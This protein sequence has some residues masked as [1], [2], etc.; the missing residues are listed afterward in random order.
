MDKLILFI[1]IVCLSWPVNAQLK[2]PGLEAGLS[3]IVSEGRQAPFWL[4]SNRQGK[5]SPDRNMAALTLAAFALPDTGKVF[6]FH[7]GAEVYARQGHSGA[8]WLHQL[9]AGFT[10]RDLLE[11]RAGLWEE[12]IGSREPSLSSGSIIWSGNAR[13]M[14]KIHIATPGYVSV[15]FTQGYAEVSGLLSHG[16]FIDDR[17]VENVLM[18]HKNFYI[19]LGGELP[20]NIHYGFNHYAQWGGNSPDYD[21][22]FPADADAYYRIFFNRA[23]DISNPGT[24]QTWENNKFGNTLGSRNYGIDMQ[25]RTINVGVYFHD[26]FED[27]SGLRRRNYPDGLWG[28]YLRITDKPRLLQA[29]VYEYLQTT[30]QSGP[31]HN[32]PDGNIIG[33]NDNYFNHAIYQSGWTYYGHTIGTPLITSPAHSS[34]ESFG[35]LPAHRIHNNRVRAHHL[36]LEGTPL[37]NWHYRSLITWSRNYGRHSVP[38]DKPA[39]QLSVMLEVSHQLPR[40]DLHLGLTL[41][42]DKGELYGDNYGVML[43][44]R[45]MFDF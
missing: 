8:L 14:P 27:G 26:I 45:K 21:L 38:F 36:G 22:P 42:A 40:P 10:W 17:Y 12:V 44:I 31:A 28:A 4:I 23:G 2:T 11:L 32:D 33:G 43:N 29:V 1:V 7:Y 30:D 39:D 35:D 37:P 41:A 6:D 34:L 15:P 18:H 24:P 9:Y 3:A 5:V 13:P 25:L 16:W 19:K 20:I